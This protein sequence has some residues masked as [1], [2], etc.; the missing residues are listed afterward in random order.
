MKHFTH[1][2]KYFV[3]PAM[4]TTIAVSTVFAYTTINSQLDPGENNADVTSLQTFLKDNASVYPEGLVTG[5]FGSLTTL[6]VNRF[7]ALYGFEQASRVG[8][9]TRDKINSLIDG[10]GWAGGNTSSDLAGPSIFNVTKSVS[11]NQATFA[12]NTN[13]TAQGKI[14]YYTSP[15]RMNEGDINSVGFGSTNG[16]TATGNNGAQMSQQITLSSLQANT[17]Y[18]YV[19]VATDAQGNVSVV[20]PNNTFTTTQ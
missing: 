19:V 14:F 6:A 16:F 3:L 20:G 13:E 2:G 7:Q 1:V 17:L 4:I 15:I 8:P 11:S 12:W 5:Y 10:G 18:Y 9:L